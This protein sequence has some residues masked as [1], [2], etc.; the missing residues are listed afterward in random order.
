MYVEFK[1]NRGFWSSQY[2][3]LYFSRRLAYFLAQV[4]LNEHF[5]VQGSIHIFCSLILIGF[6][7]IYRPFKSCSILAS[8]IISE[9]GIFIVITLSYGFNLN[10]SDKMKEI[11]EIIIMLTILS[12]I[13]LQ[14]VIS[15]LVFVNSLK[16]IWIKYLEK[17]NLEI[18]KSAS[19]N[20][21]GSFDK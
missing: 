8:N 10:I 20:I 19:E 12:V 6:L 14:L 21:S 18:A 9:V 11:I 3:F 16:I 1:N 2:Y 15:M 4:Y 17:R 7:L 5:Y 13:F